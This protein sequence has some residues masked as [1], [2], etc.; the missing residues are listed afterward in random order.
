MSNMLWDHVLGHNLKSPQRAGIVDNRTT[1]DEA[2]VLNGP[3]HASLDIGKCL[4]EPSQDTDGAATGNKTSRGMLTWFPAHFALGFCVRGGSIV[5]KVG[6]LHVWTL[7]RF[8]SSTVF[9]RTNSNS[10]EVTDP[11]IWSLRSNLA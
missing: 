10:T 8:D 7:Q 5:R 4:K 6:A 3:S 11:T 2:F 1:I 9:G